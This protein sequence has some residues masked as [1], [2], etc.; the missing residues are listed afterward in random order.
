MQHAC[1]SAGMLPSSGCHVVQQSCAHHDVYGRLVCMP[2]LFQGVRA[3]KGAEM[4]EC[5][6]DTRAFNLKISVNSR[7]ETVLQ[8]HIACAR[9]QQ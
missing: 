5:L 9:L 3:Q 6:H 7:I 8:C 1:S 2:F 4:Q